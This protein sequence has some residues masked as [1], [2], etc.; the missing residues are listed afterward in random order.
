MLQ[1]T[2][3]LLGILSQQKSILWGLT[4]GTLH[5]PDEKHKFLTEGLSKGS[6]SKLQRTFLMKSQ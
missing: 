6:G 5:A 4:F 1:T 2:P 3:L